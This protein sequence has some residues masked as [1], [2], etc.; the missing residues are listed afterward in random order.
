M[1]KLVLAIFLTTIACGDNLPARG[2]RYLRSYYAIIH[3]SQELSCESRRE[4]FSWDEDLGELW[5]FP[6]DLHQDA[7]DMFFHFERRRSGQVWYSDFRDVAIGEDDGYF[8]GWSHYSFIR[9]GGVVISTFETIK[10]AVTVDGIVADHAIFI[11]E[12]PPYNLSPTCRIV[13]HIYSL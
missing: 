2:A 9:N 4:N 1:N 7:I 5:V 11:M 12:S 3:T 8:E 10:G 6:S 13:Q